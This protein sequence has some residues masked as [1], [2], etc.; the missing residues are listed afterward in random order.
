MNEHLKFTYDSEAKASREGEF[1]HF[2]A[3]L[4]DGVQRV[5]GWNCGLSDQQNLCSIST[6]IV[7]FCI[8]PRSSVLFIHERIQSNY[9]VRPLRESMLG[10]TLHAAVMRY[11]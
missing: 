10:K 4:R 3:V 1:S 6:D 8:R 7:P 9:D 11:K 2:V 5:N